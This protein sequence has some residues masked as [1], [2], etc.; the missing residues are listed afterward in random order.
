MSDS[1]IT[2]TALISG[3]NGDDVEAYVGEPTDAPAPRGGVVLI[4]HLPG[5]D[6]STKEIARRVCELGYNVAMPNLYWREAPGADPDDAAATVRANGGVSDSQVIG[7]V[8]GAVAYLRGL[9]S[10]NGKVGVMGFCSGGRQTVLVACSINVEAAIDIT[11]GAV[12]RPPPATSGMNMPSLE[13]LLPELSCPLLGLFGNDDQ[14]P[15][16]DEVN[17]LDRILTD[18][19]KPHEFHR[20]DDTGHGFFHVDRPGYRVAAANEGWQALES[21]YGRELS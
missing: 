18:L 3:D 9:D 21:F 6:R 4:H 8:A 1:M 13:S 20:Y 10:S 16:A 7:D 15:S 19:G 14:F 12:L 5:Y 17:D 2:R 11:G